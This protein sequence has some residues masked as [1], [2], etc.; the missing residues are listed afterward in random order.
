VRLGTPPGHI[1]V[2]FGAVDG[3][4]HDIFDKALSERFTREPS[5]IEQWPDH[6]SNDF[7]SHGLAGFAILRIPTTGGWRRGF[8][9]DDGFGQASAEVSSQQY[10]RPC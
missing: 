6:D 4:Q 2:L 7:R 3:A 9:S 1:A 5:A 8:G 10:L